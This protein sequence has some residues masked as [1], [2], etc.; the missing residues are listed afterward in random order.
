M[1][2]GMQNSS[3]SS[4]SSNY[5]G[6]SCEMVVKLQVKLKF[7][8]SSKGKIQLRQISILVVKL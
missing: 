4:T 8:S 1:V 7:N 6:T 5:M 2:I 3:W